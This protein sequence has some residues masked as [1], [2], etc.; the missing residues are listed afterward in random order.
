MNSHHHTDSISVLKFS[1]RAYHALMRVG[2]CCIGDLL[3]CTKDDISGIRQLGI[4]S[5]EEITSVIDKLNEYKAEIFSERKVDNINSQEAATQKIFI[6]ND[7][8]KYLDVEI[9]Y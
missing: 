9:E 5:I 1:T 6:G 4:K 8:K 7:G 3:S 2:I